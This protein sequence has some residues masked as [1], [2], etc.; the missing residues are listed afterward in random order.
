M[1]ILILPSINISFI[2]YSNNSV[3]FALYATKQSKWV[4]ILTKFLIKT[5]MSEALFLYLWISI[6]KWMKNKKFYIKLYFS[7]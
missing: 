3:D 6:W 5:G 1:L 7:I 4:L 2:L